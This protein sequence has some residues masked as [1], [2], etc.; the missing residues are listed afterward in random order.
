MQLPIEQFPLLCFGFFVVAT[1][2]SSV[3]FGGGSSYLALLTLFL[4]SFFAIRSIALICNLVVVSG[5]TYLYF[6]NGHAKLKDF[7]PFII[8]SIPLAFLGASFRLKENIFFNI[9]GISLILSATFLALQTFNWAKSVPETKK[10]P[11]Y[12]S[13]FL[14]AGIG[15]LSGLV[16]I[17]GGIFLAPILNHLRWDKAIK[18]AALASFFIL[19]N[20]VSGLMGLVTSDSLFLPWLETLCLGIAVLLGGQL[21]IRISL[22][23]LSANGIKRVTALLVLIVGIRVLLV[24]GFGVL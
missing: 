9:L 11:G 18:I 24:N 14:G 1:L 22:K 7:L 19:V 12:L 4:G 8:T 3:G 6:K 23:R 20:S 5:S 13:Y 16:G 21:G 15:F 10:Y 2:Y 17:G